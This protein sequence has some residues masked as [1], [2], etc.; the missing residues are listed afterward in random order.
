MNGRATAGIAKYQLGGCCN[1]ATTTKATS[2]PA[3]QQRNTGKLKAPIHPPS[4]SA[5]KRFAARPVR[6][7]KAAAAR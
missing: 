2:D 1:S 3:S 5:T 7:P 4:M 6:V